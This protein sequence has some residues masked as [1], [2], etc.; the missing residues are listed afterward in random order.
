MTV[1]A[2]DGVTLAADKQTS[3][4][5]L[6]LK[7]TKA[8]RIG[9]LLVAGSGDAHRIRE[10]H[11]WVAGG[12]KKED[13]PSFQRD[14]GTSVNLMVIEAG[15]IL[16][17]GTSHLPLVIE[18]KFSAMGSGRDYALA[19]M[20]LGKTAKEAVE[21]AIHFETGCGNGVDVLELQ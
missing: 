20:Y 3:D 13:L 12:R 19:A 11:E 1:V 15:R 16:H 21:V 4:V 9:N 7:T 6:R 14:S 2:W 17:Y 8:V 10:M 18:D 5:G